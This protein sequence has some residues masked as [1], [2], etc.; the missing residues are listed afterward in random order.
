[1]AL[2]GASGVRCISQQETMKLMYLQYNKN[3]IE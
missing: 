2:T 3:V 1:M